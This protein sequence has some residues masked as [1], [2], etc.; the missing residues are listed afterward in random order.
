MFFPEG[1]KPGVR[2]LSDF[3]DMSKLGVTIGGAPFGCQLYHFV[4]AFSRREYANVVE[5]VESFEALATG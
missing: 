2:G 4:Q 5:G 1:A 3:T